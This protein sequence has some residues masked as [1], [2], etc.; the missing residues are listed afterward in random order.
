MS[1]KECS[2]S[3]IDLFNDSPI[4]S[5][6]LRS[7]QIAYNPINSLDNCTTL[8][9]FSSGSTNAYRDLA[10]T[11][12]HLKVQLVKSNG[13]PYKEKIDEVSKTKIED[14][15]NQPGF[16]NNIIHSL[17]R[18]CTVYF[19]G[20]VVSNTDFYGIKAYI[21]I[22]TNYSE[23]AIKTNFLP[24]G[25][26]K[27]E[28]NHFDAFD[29]KN[30]GYVQRKKLTNNGLILDLYS[31]IDVDIFNQPRYLINNVDVKIV[32]LLENASFYLLEK[33][34]QQSIIKIHEAQLIMRHIYVNPNIILHH[35][36]LLHKNIKIKMPFKRSEIKTYTIPSQVTSTTIDNI[37]HGKL[38]CN[39]IFTM[40][41]NTALSTRNNNP[42]NLQPHDLNYFAVYVNNQSTP[43]QP[44]HMDFTNNHYSEA[45]VEFLKNLGVYGQ[46]VGLIVTKEAWKTSC[47]M[48]PLN[49]SPL[50]KLDECKHH[51]NDGSIRFELKFKSPLMKAVTAIFYAEYDSTLEIDKN[52]NASIVG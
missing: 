28:I 6:V 16:I 42:L 25:F 29:E 4:Q 13:V 22:I 9:F 14:V 2:I 1:F 19:N 10:N 30:S 32:F 37:F 27:D 3:E 12:L 21:D 46:D 43:I 40:I 23:E 20:N 33:D 17:F 38:P 31:H 7:D 50:S 15:K 47:F 51:L 39:I 48:I 44:L 18:S 26:I 52:Y 41:D 36:Q 24:G 11:F 49:L 45:Y 5:A 34:N 8:E 35:H